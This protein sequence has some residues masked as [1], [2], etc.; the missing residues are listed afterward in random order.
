[1]VKEEV[2]DEKHRKYYSSYIP[3]DLFWGVGI[4]NET[5]LEVPNQPEV[6]GSFYKNQKR[7]RYSVNYYEG[8]LNDY[9]NKCLDTLI[10][11]DK[12]YN[13]P[14]LINSHELTKNDLSGN[15]RTNYNKGSTPNKKF[16]GKT[17]FEHMCEKDL[18]FKEEYEKSYC[19]DGD[20]VEFMT[21]NFYKKTVQDT[22]S[23]L[24]YHKKHFLEHLN[25]LKLPLANG[26]K[27]H[28]P[29][30]NH[31]FA[32]FSTNK[33]NLAIFNNGTYHFNFTMP[34]LL[35]DCGNILDKR[36]FDKKHSKAIKVFQLLEPFF[37]AKYGSGDVLSKSNTYSKRFPKG[38]Q[39][40]AA[41]RYVGAGTYDST[42]LKS[43][44]ILQE[45]RATHEPL[46]Y[47]RL[48]TQIHYAKN[49]KIG[50]D[51]NYNK[52]KNHGIELRFFDWFPEKYLEEVLTFL[53]YLLDHSS[54]LK[55][56]ENPIKN[57][58]YND[59]MYNAILNGKDTI[60]TIEQLAY[61]KTSLKL[62]IHI[63]DKN[64]VNIYNSIFNHLR[65]LY[66]SNGECS[67]Y[68]LEKQITSCSSIHY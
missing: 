50:F 24:I 44:K 35:D 49:E 9:F 57:Q 21:Q 5:Y 59:I 55:N 29:I 16:S 13:L 26:N 10:D 28:Y 56:I 62:K 17:V 20:T 51:I 23:E 18:Y 36:S 53:V 25:K 3:N 8:Y 1:M 67:K 12:S 41:S 64:I 45:D 68:M 32:R 66:K 31:G 38:S 2:T 52:F 33:N 48:Y 63:K 58:T 34:T 14:Y 22:I 15:P 46:W 27:I 30:I 47:K 37:I 39:R 6:S 4:E 7:E 65:N 11:K 60:L 42:K 19:F 61:I 54:V 43:G 40:M